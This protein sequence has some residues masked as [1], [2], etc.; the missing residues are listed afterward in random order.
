MTVVRA[1]LGSRVKLLGA[2][3]G[4]LGAIGF[5]RYRRTRLEAKAR[6]DGDSGYA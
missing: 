3:L 4:L 5:Y 1:M 6:Y 2:I